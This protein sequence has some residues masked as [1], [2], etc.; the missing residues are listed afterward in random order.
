[1]RRRQHLNKENESIF[2]CLAGLKDVER[3]DFRRPATSSRIAFA[4]LNVLPGISTT[5]GA[6]TFH[7]AGFKSRK[8]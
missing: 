4:W 8:K 3:A 6:L 1:M 7:S 5:I 2:G